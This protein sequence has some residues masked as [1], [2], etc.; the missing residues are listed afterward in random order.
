MNDTRHPVDLAFVH[1]SDIHFRKGRIGDV[2]D[3]DVEIRNEL[4][5]DLRR[6]RSRVSKLDG[7][8]ISGDI[9]FGGQVDE[10]TYARNWIESVREQLDCSADGVMVIPGNHDVDRQMVPDGGDAQKLHDE[11]RSA[12]TTE[13]RNAVIATVLRDPGKGTCL[14][15]S[16]DAYNSFARDYGCEVSRERPYWERDFILRDGTMLRI[17]GITTTFVSGPHDHVNTHKMVYGGAQ[18]QLL[19]ED[20]VRRAVVG[21]HPP[22]WTYEGDEAD[23]ILSTMSVLQLFGHK[24]EQWFARLGRGV[25]LI[26]GAMHPDRTES[27][28]LP[29]YS[30]ITIRIASD[31]QIS[32]RIYPRRWSDEEMMFIGD[33]NSAGVDYR[34]YSAETDPALQPVVSHPRANGAEHV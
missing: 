19:R 7:I 29:R 15:R 16:I 18:L 8:I 22:S 30:L 27:R 2:H 10:Y 34:D 26:A 11:I 3:A 28:W 13:E 21:H 33:F 24:H 14:M 25:R 23:R 4:E 9:A 17:R 31:R 32:F 12:A 1:L 6:I 20:N 5:R